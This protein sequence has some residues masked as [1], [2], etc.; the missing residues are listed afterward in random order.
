M[1]LLID[2]V[3]KNNKNIHHKIY[4]KEKMRYEVWMKANEGGLVRIKLTSHND[5]GS[6]TAAIVRTSLVSNI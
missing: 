6:N 2:N 3:F 5:V 4:T 1:I